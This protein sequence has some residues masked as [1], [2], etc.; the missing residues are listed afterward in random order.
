M[1]RRNGRAGPAARRTICS[2]K[3]YIKEIYFK[4][5]L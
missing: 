3:K 5:F 1:N 2:K 4:Q